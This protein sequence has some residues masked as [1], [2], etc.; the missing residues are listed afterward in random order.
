MTKTP[1]DKT[2]YD[3]TIVNIDKK[4]QEDLQSQPFF[5]R[6]IQN[7]SS[8]IGASIVLSLTIIAIFAPLLASHDPIVQNIQ[9]KTSQPLTE[10]FLLGSDELGRDIFSR[11]VYGARVSLQVG[12]ISVSIGL[13]LGGLIGL[14][15]G[16]CGGWLDKILMRLIDIMLAFPYI[17][18]TIVVVTFLGR[19][20]INA[21]IAIG[22]AQIPSY[23]RIV[24][25]A[26]LETK[27]R[28]FVKAERAL[29]VSHL[30]LMG[31]SVLPHCLSP[32]IVRLTLG[33]GDAIL[34]SAALSFLGL[35]AQ[36]PTPEWGL[37]IAT[38]REFITSAWWVITMPGICILITVLGFNILGDGLRDM[39]DPKL[40][41]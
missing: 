23:A 40:R 5:H 22:I 37:M 7:R 16:Y 10:G 36:P 17:L 27:E 3:K 12:L 8:M 28:D 29:G 25:V 39:L 14:I 35:G 41:L 38:G 26:V 2:P 15:A 4:G 31:R 1:Y 11:I 34:S 33:I 21:M 9:L 24:R 30:V 18:L 6:F 32:V 13:L 20:I 19:S